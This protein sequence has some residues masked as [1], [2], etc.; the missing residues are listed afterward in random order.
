M[1]YLR[2]LFPATHDQLLWR[3]ARFRAAATNHAEIDAFLP[4]PLKRSSAAE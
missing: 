4:A 3:S 1:I 2:G